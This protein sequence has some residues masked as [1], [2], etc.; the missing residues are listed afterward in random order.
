M[1][2]EV[3]WSG[4]RGGLWKYAGQWMNTVGHLIRGSRLTLGKATKRGS[5]LQSQV[6]VV[7][8]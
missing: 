7:H 8:G 4:H 2:L 6:D 5:Q 1:R 3:S